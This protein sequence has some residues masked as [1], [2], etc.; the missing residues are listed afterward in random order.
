MD[1]SD[2]LNYVTRVAADVIGLDSVAAEDDFIGIGGDSLTATLVA[3]D[4]SEHGIDVLPHH[5][6]G[7]ET[8]RH[9]AQVLS[10]QLSLLRDDSLSAFD[11][12][13]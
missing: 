8:F 1:E 12:V 5:L 2:I 7:A 10:R 9:L 11:D 13:R 6:L 3:S 4:L